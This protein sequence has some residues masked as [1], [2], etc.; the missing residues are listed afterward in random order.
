MTGDA[1]FC[2]GRHFSISSAGIIPCFRKFGALIH[3][4]MNAH[5]ICADNHKVLTF[6]GQP[7]KADLFVI[8][9]FS[10]Q[11]GQFDIAAL[12]TQHH[13]KNAILDKAA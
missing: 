11:I 6:M 1:F 5:A 13:L 3:V 10:K 9:T 2:V 7:L 12:L 4:A 8:L